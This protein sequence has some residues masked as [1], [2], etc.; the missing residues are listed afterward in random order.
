MIEVTVSGNV[1]ND[2]RQT[3]GHSFFSV[4]S[5]D[6]DKDG[7]KV[8]TWVDVAVF[9]KANLDVSQV[10]KGAYVTV[11]GYGTLETYKDKTSL[12]VRAKSLEVGFK[13]KGGQNDDIPF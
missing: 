6:K 5:S 1:G 2:P 7:N 3:N 11:K 9:A 4:A 10:K 13:A 8:T 12:K